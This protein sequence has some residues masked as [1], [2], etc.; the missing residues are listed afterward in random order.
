MSCAYFW[1]FY[2]QMVHFVW[3]K[4]LRFTPL[5]PNIK[6]PKDYVEESVFQ[7]EYLE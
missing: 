1:K 2:L 7:T 4:N 6:I 3:K 5:L